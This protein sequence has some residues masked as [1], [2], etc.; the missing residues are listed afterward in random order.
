MDPDQ[1]K[2][3]LYMLQ[4]LETPYKELTKWEEEF[5]AS[6]KEQFER[7]HNL[8]ERQFEILERIYT[9]KTA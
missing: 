3:V 7:T 4:D 6:V 1:H 9:E 2:L 8:S 5:V